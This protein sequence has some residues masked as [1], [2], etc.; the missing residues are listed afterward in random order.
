MTVLMA[1]QTQPTKRVHSL[2]RLHLHPLLLVSDSPGGRKYP[3]TWTIR[4]QSLAVRRIRFYLPP[5]FTPPI[6]DLDDMWEYTAHKLL[7]ELHQH[8]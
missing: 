2:L 5:G 6:T 1:V 8:I 4:W 7:W 3:A